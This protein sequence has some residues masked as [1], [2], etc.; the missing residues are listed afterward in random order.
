V[1]RHL[2]DILD[3]KKLRQLNLLAVQCPDIEAFREALLS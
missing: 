1:T 2:R 3:E